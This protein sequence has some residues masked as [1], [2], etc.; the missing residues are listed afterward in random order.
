MQNLLDQHT[1]MTLSRWE[2]MAA[3]KKALIYISA[4]LLV[5]ALAL[6]AWALINVQ[7]A[8]SVYDESL[9][10]KQSLEYAQAAVANED[11]ALAAKDLKEAQQHFDNA[12]NDF[13]AFKVYMI[14]PGLSEQIRAIDNILQAGKNLSSGLGKLADLAVEIE[15]V[16]KEE[17]GDF[18]FGDITEEE[19]ERVLEK[20]A[21]S[22]ADLQGLKSEIELAV[23]LIDEIP[24]DELYAPIQE[25]VAPVKEQLPLLEAVVNQFIPAA[26]S[27][28]QILGYPNKKTYLF[29]LQNNREL[30]P[31]GGFIGTYGILQVENAEI[32]KFE[33]DNIYNLDNQGKDTITEPAP[34]PIS[35]HTSTQNWL[36]RD[37]NWSP[38]FPQTARK[39]EEKYYEEGGT[40]PNVDGVIAVTPT[41]IESLLDLTGPIQVGDLEF[42]SENLFEQLEY[43]VEFGYYEQGITDANRK[44]VIGD[45]AS[46]LMDRLFS[47][48]R[49]E[50]TTLW[51][52]FVQDIDSKQ[53][54]VYVDDPITQSLVLEQNWGGEMK[55]YEDDYLMF[56]DANL[57]ALKTDDVMERE[58]TYSV[59]QFDGTYYGTAEMLYRNTGWFSGFHTRYRTHTRVYLPYG[60]E[61]VEHSGFLTGDKTQNGAPTDPEVYEES[62]THANGTTVRY[63]VVAGFTSIEPQQEG[64]I[65]L[66]YKL[67]PNVADAIESGDYDLYI[68]KQAGTI[69]HGLTVNFDV[70]RPLTSTFP[71]DKVSEIR[72]NSVSYST[73]LLTDRKFSITLD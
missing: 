70:G 5:I 23:F 66:R 20:L 34:A 32:V 18:S 7:R 50:L 54:L 69:A 61:L 30:R 52:T 1:D 59:N 67:P 48:P 44:E 63:T 24:D 10:A 12:L 72:E 15:S 26:Q 37:I 17:E 11:F 33:T 4:S 13:A 68:Q 55:L 25:A 41:F 58:L 8:Q 71:L 3:W 65:R 53:I 36:L 16:L 38:D 60:A 21:Q 42:N 49:S 43:Q 64:T 9:E 39:A 46:I 57:A 62:F 6:G 40:E 73:D 14:I 22:P 31:T 56:V 47:M 2:R 45:L 19:K 27:L 51:D 29:L 28:P 35:R